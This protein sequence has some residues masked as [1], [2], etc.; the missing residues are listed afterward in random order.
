MVQLDHLLYQVESFVFR[1]LDKHKRSSF[2][3]LFSSQE[4]E[5]F[6]IIIPVNAYRKV[7]KHGRKLGDEV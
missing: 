3:L 2:I 1:L 5:R 4:R 6:I 7:D